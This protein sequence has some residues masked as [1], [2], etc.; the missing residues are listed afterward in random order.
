MSS[1]LLNETCAE[2]IMFRDRLV[3]ENSQELF[4]FQAVSGEFF[5]CI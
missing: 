2:I 5:F 4:R 3:S 1:T